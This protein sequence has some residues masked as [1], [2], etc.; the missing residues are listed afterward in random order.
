MWGSPLFLFVFFSLLKCILSKN[1]KN[2]G[3][4]K[5]FVF[6]ENYGNKYKKVGN[7]IR[8]TYVRD[9]VKC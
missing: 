3:G 9:F 6:F 2:G 7:C 1:W 4:N 5:M 8:L